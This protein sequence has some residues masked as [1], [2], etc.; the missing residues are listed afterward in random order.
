M[1]KMA[2]L[3]HVLLGK[4]LKCLVD[5][6]KKGI[7]LDGRINKCRRAYKRRDQ[8]IRERGGQIEET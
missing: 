5:R 3:K 1:I 6:P 4:M 7:R 8:Q 2:V